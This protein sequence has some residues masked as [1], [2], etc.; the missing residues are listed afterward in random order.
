[1]IGSLTY[2]L[3]IMI[4]KLQKSMGYDVLRE[5][6]CDGV[7]HNVQKE[8]GNVMFAD[9]RAILGCFLHRWWYI[10]VEMILKQE[11]MLLPLMLLAKLL[12]S[13]MGSIN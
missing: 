4:L 11:K 6:T 12:N 10:M 9:V 13:E 5:L 7:V 1:M 2:S 8:Q 3:H